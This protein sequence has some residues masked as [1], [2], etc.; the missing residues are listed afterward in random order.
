MS[1]PGLDSGVSTSNVSAYVIDSHDNSTFKHEPYMRNINLNGN[2]H[3]MMMKKSIYTGFAETQDCTKQYRYI[4]QIRIT[5]PN[6][7][8]TALYLSY[9]S[10]PNY[11][12]H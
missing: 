5:W 1:N 7:K 6:G 2:D 9:L 8:L 11:P 12:A 3:C 4:C 10:Y